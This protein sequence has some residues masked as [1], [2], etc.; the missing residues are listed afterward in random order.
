MKWLLIISL[1]L[2]MSLFSCLNKETFEVGNEIEKENENREENR[3]ENNEV[4]NN[5]NN[6]K[7]S[8]I[9]SID[10]VSKSGDKIYSIP[11][12]FEDTF[13]K[14]LKEEIDRAKKTNMNTL[15]KDEMTSQPTGYPV[16]EDKQIEN[17]P[18]ENANNNSSVENEDQTQNTHGGAN[19]NLPDTEKYGYS[20][21]FNNPLMEYTPNNEP[22][23]EYP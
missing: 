15:P 9:G 6:N 13:Y 11:V 22:M 21:F 19:D 18:S 16:N 17:T 4:S 8:G 3:E 7:P 12:S 2:L 5:K 23:Y 14:K 10:F 20:R 1:M